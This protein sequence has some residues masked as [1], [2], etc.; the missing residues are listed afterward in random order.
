MTEV[1]GGR[2]GVRD[3]KNPS[4]P[5]SVFTSAERAAFAGGVKRDEFG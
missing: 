5:V 2:K 3:G 1:S 4:G